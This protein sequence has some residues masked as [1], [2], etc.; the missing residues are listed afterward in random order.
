M[1]LENLKWLTRMKDFK[2]EET[3]N[4]LNNFKFKG[5]RENLK[6]KKTKTCNA[7]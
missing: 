7:R 5:K 2:L 1:D 3:L 4:N 6:G